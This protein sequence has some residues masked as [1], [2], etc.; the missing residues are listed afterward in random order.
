MT[1][2]QFNTEIMRLAAALKTNPRLLMGS[3][4]GQCETEVI[5][6]QTICACAINLEKHGQAFSFNNI[7]PSEPMRGVDNH[8]AMEIL[9]DGYLEHAEF[10][11]RKTLIPTPAMLAECDR[12]IKKKSGAQ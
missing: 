7:G 8:R 10:D 6:Q 2:D 4:W 1:T 11:G 9:N 3:V 12:L 5:A